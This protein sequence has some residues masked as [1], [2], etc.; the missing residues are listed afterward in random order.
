MI[1]IELK[2]DKTGQVFKIDPTKIR[3]A[4]VT[5]D[6]VRVKLYPTFIKLT[7]GR[8]E[9]VSGTTPTGTRELTRIS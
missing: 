6:G 2:D 9:K 4:I 3:D 8:N 7:V 5:K 1:K